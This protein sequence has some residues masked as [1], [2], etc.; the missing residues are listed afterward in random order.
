MVYKKRVGFF[1]F[2]LLATGTE[3]LSAKPNPAV[4]A[5]L[6]AGRPF[7]EGELLVQFNSGAS[8]AAKSAA[9]TKRGAK[10]AEKLLD[11][12]ARKD[13]KGDLFQAKLGKGRKVDAALIAQL[14]ADPAVEYVEPNWIYSTQL[15]NPNDPGIGMLWACRVQPRRLLPPMAAVR[16]PAGTPGRCVPTKFTWASSTKA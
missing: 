7:V 3:Q 10:A 8:E 15:A 14:A 13:A 11:K 12:A 9:L 1:M 16:W 6:K 2:A 5:S 4:E